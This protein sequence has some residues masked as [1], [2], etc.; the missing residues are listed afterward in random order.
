MPAVLAQERDVFEPVEPVGVVDHDRVG[1]AVAEGRGT[2]RRCGG[3]R[4]CWRRSRRRSAACALSSL[5]EGSPT[6]VVPPPISTIGR[7][8]V[9][10]HSRS[11]MICRQ[12]ADM[13]A[14]GGAIEA[15]I[16]G[17]PAR[18]RGGASS[19]SRSVHW[20][21]KPRSSATARKVGAGGGHRRFGACGMGRRLSTIAVCDT[22]AG[23]AMSPRRH[24]ALGLMSGT[25]LD[26]VD[27]GLVA[28][29]GRDRGRSAGRA[30]TVP[31][32]AGVPRAPARRCS[33][34]GRRRR[35]SSAT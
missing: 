10:C 35:R 33:A 16:G 29:D 6:L 17:R 18:R 23:T 26:G 11:S 7:L 25:S 3:C 9:C 22:V 31:Y 27:A 4:P 1:R 8:P 34:A 28:T 13:Q 20:W 19:A 24:R 32:D 30:L 12:A 5:P 2:G 14:V 21:M 15:D